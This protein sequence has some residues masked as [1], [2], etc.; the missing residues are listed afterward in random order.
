MKNILFESNDF[1]MVTYKTKLKVGDIVKHSFKGDGIIKSITNNI[2]QIEYDNGSIV[3]YF[4]NYLID[5]K[6]LMVNNN[7]NNNNY[8]NDDEEEEEEEEED[9]DDDYL[10]ND[11]TIDEL[12]TIKIEDFFTDAELEL[13]ISF[14]DLT[15]HE[16]NLNKNINNTNNKFKIIYNKRKINDL[17]ILKEYYLYLMK[18]IPNFNIYKY[19]GNLPY[20]ELWDIRQKD[21]IDIPKDIKDPHIFNSGVF[22]YWVFKNGVIFK[23]V[24]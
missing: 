13:L 1:K 21:R 4:I 15:K 24:I 17:K 16:N 23:P 18:K 19:S 22:Y 6:S 3:D 7:N 20:T 14:N 11:I 2:I 9:D 8:I 12:M 10:F 5:T